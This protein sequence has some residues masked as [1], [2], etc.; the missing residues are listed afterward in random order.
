[1]N[2]IVDCNFGVN[3]LK[4]YENY[5][6]VIIVECYGGYYEGRFLGGFWSCCLECYVGVVSISKW[7]GGGIDEFWLDLWIF[8]YC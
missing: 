2:V 4:S 1:M 3:K 6:W 5:F 8:W 7:V